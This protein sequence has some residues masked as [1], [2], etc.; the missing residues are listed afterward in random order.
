MLKT[1]SSLGNAI[2]STL[3]PVKKNWEG[4]WRPTTEVRV[5]TRRLNSAFVFCSFLQAVGK[6]SRS[7]ESQLGFGEPVHFQRWR[8]FLCAPLFF[9][10]PLF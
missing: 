5:G 9:V 1:V 4:S 8:N 10:L 3:L 7:L 6:K 2:L